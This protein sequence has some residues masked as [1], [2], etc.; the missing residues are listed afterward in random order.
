[1]RNL[2][3]C[4][5]SNLHRHHGPKYELK[6][7]G[8]DHFE[9]VDSCKIRIRN[10]F[11]NS[12]TTCI[13]I[14]ILIFRFPRVCTLA[15]ESTISIVILIFRFLDIGSMHV[16][17]RIKSLG[18]SEAKIFAKSTLVSAGSHC[19]LYLICFF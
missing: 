3:P 5:Q 17:T 18:S 2:Y 19:K 14:L 10:T 11:I 9:I 7:L 12:S 15:L 8:G 13:S 6:V 4:C 16:G 1:M